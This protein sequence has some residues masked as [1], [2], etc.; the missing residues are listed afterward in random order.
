MPTQEPSQEILDLLRELVNKSGKELDA[1]QKEEFYHLLLEFREIFAATSAELGCTDKFKHNI[2]T[3]KAPLVRQQ[4]CC[5]PPS[6]RSE[7]GGPGH[8][9]EK[10]DTRVFQ[11]LGLSDSAGKEKRW[12]YEVLR[13]LSTVKWSDT[14]GCLSFTSNRHDIWHASWFAVVQHCW[15]FEWILASG[16]DRGSPAQD[17]VLHHRRPIWVQCSPLWTL[18]CPGH[19]SVINGPGSSRTQVVTLLGLSGWRYCD[20]QNL[21]R[22]PPKS[23]TC[24]W[25]AERGRTKTEAWK[26]LILSRTGTLSRAHRVKRWN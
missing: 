15:S 24:V 20:Q 19:F 23:L 17:C 3:G 4:V 18:Q 2:Y 16:E 26:V 7:T 10:G 9:A 14:E 22:P 12:F 8:V 25:V 5:I 21:F 11:P 13:R 6:C 1:T